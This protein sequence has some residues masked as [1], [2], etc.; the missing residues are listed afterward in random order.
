MPGNNPNVNL[1]KRCTSQGGGRSA[2]DTLYNRTIDLIMSR[3]HVKSGGGL[4][5]SGYRQLEYIEANGTQYIKTN[6]TG[7]NQDYSFV[8]DMTISSAGFGGLYGIYNVGGND[9]IAAFIGHTTGRIDYVC[10]STGYK[11]TTTALPRDTRYTIYSYP[12][13]FVINGVEYSK[14]KADITTSNPLML[15]S[16]L[17]WRNDNTGHYGKLHEAW[18]YDDSDS[19]VLHG[20]PALL[21]ADSKP[22]LYD[23][24]SDTFHTNAGTGEFLYA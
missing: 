19:L 21:E 4:L 6:I 14:S 16:F 3:R 9:R 5:P 22:G 23:V 17:V 7:V 8:V 10:G 24:V 11:T 13:K 15:L 2:T 20:I 18:V 1:R 12:T